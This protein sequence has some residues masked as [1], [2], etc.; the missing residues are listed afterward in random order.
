MPACG[1]GLCT[2]LSRSVFGLSGA[3]AILRTP[4]SPLQDTK[5]IYTQTCVYMQWILQLWAFL[6]I[7][8]NAFPSLAKFTF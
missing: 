8:R 7:H 4:A 6:D 1:E 5:E 3:W 2:A